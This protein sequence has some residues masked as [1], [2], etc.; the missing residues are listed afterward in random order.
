MHWKLGLSKTWQIVRI[1]V[2]L[3]SGILVAFA[4]V[5]VMEIIKLR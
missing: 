3:G 1:A 4:V 5:Y 2:S